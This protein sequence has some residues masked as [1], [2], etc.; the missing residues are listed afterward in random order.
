M[1]NCFLNHLP[2]MFSKP[3]Q[4]LV[5]KYDKSY[6][7]FSE[8]RIKLFLKVLTLIDIS[9]VIKETNP[10]ATYQVFENLFRSEFENFFLLQKTG[11]NKSSKSWFDPKLH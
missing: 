6:C 3:T 9:T 4:N 7:F 5:N 10:K 11:K 8:A 2:V 1:T